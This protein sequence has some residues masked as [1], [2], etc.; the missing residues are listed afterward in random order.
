MRIVER[1]VYVIFVALNRLMCA[2]AMAAR[3]KN[4]ESRVHAHKPV[5]APS[6]AACVLTE[7]FGQ[8]VSSSFSFCFTVNGVLAAII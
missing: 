7:T 5:V 1:G 3:S 8:N 6:L 2:G 4:K